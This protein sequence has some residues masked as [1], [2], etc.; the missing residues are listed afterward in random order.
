VTPRARAAASDPTAPSSPPVGPSPEVDEYLEHLRGERDVSP[1]T[2]LAYGRDLK[3]L[4][5]FF[6][7]YY[8]GGAWTWQGVDRLAIRG[9]L[10][11][12]TRRGLSK[13]SIARALSAVRGFYRFLHRNEVVDANPARAVG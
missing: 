10:A 6:S 12:L 11:H 4:V 8:G 13:R 1:N 7:N 3:E 2:I 9:F 5:E